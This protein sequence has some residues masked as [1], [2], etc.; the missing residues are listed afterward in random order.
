M[1]RLVALVGFAVMLGGRGTAMATPGDEAPGGSETVSATRDHE[2]SPA[3]ALQL[4]WWNLELDVR[5]R[6]GIFVDVGV[7]WAG[8]VLGASTTGTDWVV[9]VGAKLGYEY[10]AS[11]HLGLRAGLRG[12][13]MVSSED[14]CG[15]CSHLEHR[16]YALAEVGVRYELSSGLILGLDVPL[17]AA[18]D[19]VDSPEALPPPGSLG[20]SAVYLGW[21]L[22]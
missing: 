22:R 14:P 6:A 21:R 11:A 13:Y 2:P 19:L 3:L 1:R 4:G 9:P 12:A 5:T 15:I 10:R 18:A 7:P 20:F 16:L 17:F 8:F